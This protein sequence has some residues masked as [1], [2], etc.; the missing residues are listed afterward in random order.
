MSAGSAGGADGGGGG[1]LPAPRVFVA[2]ASGRKILTLIA[3]SLCLVSVEVISFVLMD[4][5]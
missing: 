3:Y 4:L 1:H 2:T 5:L